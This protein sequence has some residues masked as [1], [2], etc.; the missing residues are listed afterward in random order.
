MKIAI[1]C[2]DRLGFPAIHQLLPHRLIVAVGTTN[3]VPETRLVLKQLCD[4][5]NIPLN[6]FS[7]K[8]LEE[9]LT[10]WLDQYQPD[11]VLVKT[12][13]YK[14]PTSVLSVPKYGFINF[15]YAPLPAYRGS[16]PLFWMIRNG[17]SDGGV[18]IH[19]MDESF[20]TGEILLQHPVMMTPETNYGLAISQLAATGAALTGNLLQGL[21]NN[22]LQSA[23]QDS[24]KAGWYG[25]PKVEDLT[26]KWSEM[27]ASDICCLVNACNPWN[28]GAIVRY[29][30]WTFALTDVSVSNF[31]VPQGTP[32]GSILRINEQDGLIISCKSNQAIIVNV[33]YTEEGFFGGHRLINF[34]IRKGIQLDN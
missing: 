5:G 10:K 15:H 9:S 23:K 1:L 19:K 12:F 8:D 24:S 17:I 6:L 33:V 7:N 21:L 25:R 2:N 3:R 29:R 20:D 18:T 22:T 4:Q 16:N 32:P 14:I 34:G 11:V 28:K 26:I 30:G 13:P 31:Q 27:N